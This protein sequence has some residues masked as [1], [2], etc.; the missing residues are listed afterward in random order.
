MPTDDGTLMETAKRRREVIQLREAGATWKSIAETLENRHG[1]ESLPSGWDERYA[2]KDFKREL[3]K[4]Q[5][6]T[7]ESRINRMLQG[8]WQKAVGGKEVTWRQQREAID[9]AIRLS[10]RR[11]KLKGLDA[12]EQ[13]ELS[14]NPDGE[15]LKFQWIDPDSIDEASG[16]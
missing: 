8:I 14:G 1:A 7:A 16:G 3:N 13:M 6:E 15:P 9:R 5:D 4:I 10:K 11:A 12:P 2:Y